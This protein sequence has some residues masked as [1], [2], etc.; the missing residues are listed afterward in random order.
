MTKPIG[1]YKIYTFSYTYYELKVS[2][3]VQQE[4]VGE[5]I[6]RSIPV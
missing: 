4:F 1:G 6:L 3:H 5:I 2:I